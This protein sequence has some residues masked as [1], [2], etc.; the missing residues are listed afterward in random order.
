MM[1]WIFLVTLLFW[2]LTSTFFCFVFIC[3]NLK[4]ISNYENI[5]KWAIHESKFQKSNPQFQCALSRILHT[6]WYFLVAILSC[7]TKSD[8]QM[9]HT[10]SKIRGAIL[11][12]HMYTM[13]FFVRFF[14]CCHTVSQRWNSKNFHTKS[15]FEPQMKTIAPILE[16]KEKN[17]VSFFNS[18]Q[19]EQRRNRFVCWCSNE[20]LHFFHIA[21][22]LN[23]M[24]TLEKTARI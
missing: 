17:F 13:A 9:F 5:I 20:C 21:S 7:E 18:I 19:L 12:A 3:K 11:L 1:A 4:I 2:I 15:S 16:T 6:L 24:L 8:V 14:L 23:E 10:L 22:M